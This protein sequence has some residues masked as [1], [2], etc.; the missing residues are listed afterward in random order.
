MHSLLKET[1]EFRG[2]PMHKVLNVT[3]EFDSP[4]PR[5]VTRVSWTRKDHRLEKDESN[6][7]I[8]EVPT[9]S[10][11]RIGPTKRLKDKRARLGILPNIYTS[12][13][14]TTRLHSFRMQKSG[15][16]PKCLSK[17]VCGSFRCEYEYPKHILLSQVPGSIPKIPLKMSA[18]VEALTF[19]G[20][21]P[22][23]GCPRCVF[24]CCLWLKSMLQVF[25][26]AQFMLARTYRLDSPAKSYCL[27]SSTSYFLPCS[28]ST[29]TL[30]FSETNARI[31]PSLWVFL[32]WCRTRTFPHVGRVTPL[33]PLHAVLPP[34]TL[35]TLHDIKIEHVSASRQQTK[36]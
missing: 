3:Q 16:S 24:W 30:R 23:P 4:S 5:Y 10:N 35:K 19:I 14:R 12:S 26:R 11:S 28:T 2:K 7:N 29:V 6:F 32:A 8:S 13:K 1:K 15:F 36:S 21:A 33:I 18:I 34:S 31:M 9:L 22:R 25:A 20:W 27:K 17:R